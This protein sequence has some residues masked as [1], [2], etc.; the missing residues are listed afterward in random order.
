MV[1]VPIGLVI[2]GLNVGALAHQ[3]GSLLPAKWVP[4]RASAHPQDASSCPYLY[5]LIAHRH[6]ADG[7]ECIFAPDVICVLL[8][9][10]SLSNCP[11]SPLGGI[12]VVYFAQMGVKIS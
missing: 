6:G 10:P 7:T 1:T 8:V 5:A 12:L 9:V 2:A 11:S 4:D 3:L